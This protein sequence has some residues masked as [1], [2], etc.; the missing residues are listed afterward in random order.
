[1]DCCSQW[2]CVK[3]RV[4]RHSEGLR[5]LWLSRGSYSVCSGQHEI[6]LLGQSQ[7]PTA[8]GLVSQQQN[9]S[10]NAEDYNEP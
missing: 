6:R 5:G 9:S 1:M 8:C 3:L 4:S 2:S 10:W 7:A